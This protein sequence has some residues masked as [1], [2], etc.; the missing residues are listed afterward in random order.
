MYSPHL[1]VLDFDGLQVAL[2]GREKDLSRAGCVRC[3][4]VAGKWNEE[5]NPGFRR[6]LL[7]LQEQMAHEQIG[8]GTAFSRAV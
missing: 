1:C 2:D 4:T 7:S 8:K 6:G 5:K 3:R